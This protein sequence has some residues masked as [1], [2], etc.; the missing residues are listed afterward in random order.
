MHLLIYK[1][2]LFDFHEPRH[3]LSV[4]Y[5]IKV[6]MGHSIFLEGQFLEN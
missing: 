2:Y 1:E 6:G 4:N 3:N 5:P